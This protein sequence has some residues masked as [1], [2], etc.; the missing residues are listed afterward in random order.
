[1]KTMLV[2]C[3]KINQSVPQRKVTVTIIKTLLINNLFKK[4]QS[5]LMLKPATNKIIQLAR[6]TL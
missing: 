3:K 5:A 6:C 1:V 2:S 4:M